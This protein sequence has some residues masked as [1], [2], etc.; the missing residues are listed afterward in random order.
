MSLTISQTMIVLPEKPLIIDEGLQ[1]Q[2]PF[3]D[4]DNPQLTGMYYAVALAHAK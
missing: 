4:L 3:P 2:A 1:I